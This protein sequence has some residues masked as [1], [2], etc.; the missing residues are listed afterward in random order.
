[1]CRWCPKYLR[2]LERL[3]VVRVPGS[4]DDGVILLGVNLF[5]CVEFA[6]VQDKKNRIRGSRVWPQILCAARGASQRCL[7]LLHRTSS[8]IGLID[9]SSQF[10]NPPALKKWNN[11]LCPLYS[12]TT[13][14][15]HIGIRQLYSGSV[16]MMGTLS[17]LVM[18]TGTVS[19]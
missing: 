15:R 8:L 10:S 2:W 9:S 7:T 12:T 17:H 19:K 3:G 11:L 6:N 14:N 16:W 13:T 5:C 1:M 4:E 18:S